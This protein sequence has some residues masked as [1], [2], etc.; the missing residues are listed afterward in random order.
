MWLTQALTLTSRIECYSNE[1][2]L[3]RRRCLKHSWSSSDGARRMADINGTHFL[4]QAEAVRIPR[5]LT[6]QTEGLEK[7]AVRSASIAKLADHQTELLTGEEAWSRRCFDTPPSGP[8][9]WFIRG[10]LR[11]R[12]RHLLTFPIRYFQLS[13]LWS[14][15]IPTT[16]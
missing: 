14:A 5:L 7:L 10:H 2:L 8:P 4:F 1:A 3:D 11:K 15:L 16:W 12:M 9:R 6:L 13:P